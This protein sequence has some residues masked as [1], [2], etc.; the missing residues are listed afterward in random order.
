M[1]NEIKNKKGLV[2]AALTSALLLVS[3]NTQAKTSSAATPIHFGK[4]QVS[5]VITGKLSP[6]QDA[7]WYQFGAAAGQFALINITPLSGTSETANVGI[8]Q[9]PDGS[10]DGNKGG[11]VYQGCLPKTGTY[12]LKMGRNLMATNGKTAGYR[13][14]VII[15]PKYA[16]R[17]LCD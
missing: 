12:R 14:E 13:T 6:N 1:I 10:E 11:I 17:K 9:M 3:L 16:S 15:L 5:T 8:L 4:G 2:A 7:A